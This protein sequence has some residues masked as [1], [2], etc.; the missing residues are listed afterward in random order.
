MLHNI[1]VGKNTAAAGRI[2]SVI[3]II[4]IQTGSNLMN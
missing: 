4:I 2:I 3:V 1:S